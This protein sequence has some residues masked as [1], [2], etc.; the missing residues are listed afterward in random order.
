M[1]T[2]ES[3]TAGIAATAAIVAPV[4]MSSRRLMRLAVCSMQFSYRFVVAKSQL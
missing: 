2:A 3:P 1:V 4:A